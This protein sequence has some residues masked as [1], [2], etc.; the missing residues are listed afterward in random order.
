MCLVSKDPRLIIMDV[1]D[2]IKEAI[3][4]YYSGNLTC[5]EAEELLE[6]VDKD[7]GN[8]VLFRQLWDTWRVSGRLDPE[9]YSTPGCYEELLKRIEQRKER[10]VPGK[11]L[12]FRVSLLRNV[13]A[14]ALL[15]VS[16]GIA[17]LLL[18]KT[19][20]PATD[21]PR[22]IENISPK[23]SRSS[24]LLPDG[25]TIWLN[26]DTRIKYAVDYAKTDRNVFLEGEAYFKVAGNESLPFVVITS[27]LSITALGT[28]FNVKAYSNERTIET[29]LEEGQ[30]V[31]EA[32]ENMAG[33]VDFEPVVLSKN[34]NAVYVKHEA[35]PVVVAKPDSQRPAEDMP[36]PAEISP[37]PVRVDVVDDTRLFTSWKDSRWVFKDEKL[38][39]LA[40]KLE[41]RYNAV[42][43]IVDT[44][45]LDYSFTG[46]LQDETLEQ[47]LNVIKY[48]APIKYRMNLNQVVIY[49]D[50]LLKRQF[51]SQ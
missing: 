44:T 6:W 41:R 29:T 51:Y 4:N 47:I 36:P 11:V 42:I 46:T 21:A 28:A 1:T 17:G 30:V 39:T 13:A 49:E 31:I 27:D 50:Q 26:A 8:L 32:L 20:A 25:T 16:A 43:T 34:E 22:Y 38:R 18:R 19:E 12:T 40:P 3:I 15:L 33:K 48:S 35:A 7:R 24:V 37:I 23:G 2:K 45:L 14:I 9:E 10:K 5:D